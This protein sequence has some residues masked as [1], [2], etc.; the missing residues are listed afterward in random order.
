MMTVLSQLPDASRRPS[1]EKATEL[2]QWLWP[3][4]F[5][6]CCS[7]PCSSVSQTIAVL[8][9]LPDASRRPSG[10]KATELTPLIWLSSVY[11]NAP[12]SVFQIRTVWSS[13]ADASRR[14][15]GEKATEL[16]QPVWPSS[17][18]KHR[19]QFSSTSGFVLIHDGC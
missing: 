6:T 10:E 18:C 9:S 1:G 3:S 12:I 11:C 7:R 16:T 19:L 13:E 8:P 4:S 2:T 15:S 17:V 5:W 14:P